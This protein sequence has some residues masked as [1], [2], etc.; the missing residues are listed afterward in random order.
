MLGA[1]GLRSSP[2]ATPSDPPGG[3]LLA[4]P[5]WLGPYAKD[6]SVAVSSAVGTRCDVAMSLGHLSGLTIRGATADDWDVISRL[7]ERSF[8][9][10]ASGTRDTERALFE[11]DRTVLAVA[12]GREVGLGS[13]FSL[14]MSVPGG[15]LLPTAGVTWVGVLATH[16]R[17]GVLTSMM[18]RMLEG[19]RDNGD[20]VAALWASDPA[21]YGRFGYGIAT[22]ALSLTIPTTRGTLGW[23]PP[24][25][26]L[27][28]GM[29]EA[30][31]VRADI[32]TVAE[33]VAGHRAGGIVRSTA[34]WDAHLQDRPEDRGGQSAA[35]A[36]VVRDDAGPRAFAVFRTS[37]AFTE[38]VAAGDLSVREIG[39]VDPDAA[40]R[41]WRTL[42]G[43]DLIGRVSVRN[44]PVDDPLLWLLSDP[45]SPQATVK[46]GLHV[47]LV[48]V[49]RALE[50]RTY[51]QPVDVVLDLADPF[52]PWCAGRYRLT[53][54]PDGASCTP[55][56]D[57]ADL[58]LRGAE[59]GTADPVRATLPTLA[60][61]GG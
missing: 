20:P 60:G 23:A 52:A 35:R 10:T 27:E 7:D 54:G 56:S 53:A 16:R 25:E 50:S 12:D 29:T 2:T 59:L 21:I 33:R 18:R 32:V 8:G 47:R 5:P 48:D 13:V 58:A 46:D 34:F 42:L 40:A 39:Y 61:A 1:P 28:V 3:V 30:V 36:F 31:D 14:A 38:P 44:L 55:T 4:L 45:R 43:H 22:R 19:A 9:F 57:S 51:A 17:R 26:G 15:R 24:S 41:L 37:I 6:V 11:F 49:P